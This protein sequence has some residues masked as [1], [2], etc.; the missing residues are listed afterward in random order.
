MPTLVANRQRYQA[1]GSAAVLTFTR[2][3]YADP[4]PFALGGGGISYLRGYYFAPPT[5]QYDLAAPEAY[6]KAA[7]RFILSRGIFARGG[8]ASSFYRGYIFTP[9]ATPFTTVWPA[10]QLFLHARVIGVTAPYLADWLETPLQ[11]ALISTASIGV[12]N[13]TLSPSGFQFTPPAPA[14]GQARPKPLNPYG[15]SDDTGGS[16]IRPQYVK[17]NSTLKAK[18]FGLIS[19]LFSITEGELGSQ[20]GSNTAFF[21]VETDGPAQLYI[22]NNS[23]AAFTSKYISVGLL[24][25]D[26]KA[27][28]LNPEGFAYRNDNIATQSNESAESL[29]P[30]VYY[31]TISCNQWQAI[32]FSVTM[33]VIRFKAMIGAAGGTF[34]PYGRFAQA[35][36]FSAA[37]LTGPLRGYIPPDS[38]IDRLSGAATGSLTPVL[39]LAI[40]RGAAV[41]TMVPYGRLKQTHRISGTAIGSGSS[42]A[43]LSSIPPYG[44]GYG[45]GY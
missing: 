12:F 25:S 7:L 36:L 28:P 21:V 41:G 8:G 15:G 14:S 32:P 44:G 2:R 33:Q 26:R 17:Y 40:M 6:P 29:P 43:T 27:I 38:A 9:T 13:W 1:E 5:A 18:N 11:R 19:N 37:T 42:I 4:G 20:A 34:A 31:F 16:F 30:G 10:S 24:D 22:K 23:T 35:K 45:G 3:F 39:S